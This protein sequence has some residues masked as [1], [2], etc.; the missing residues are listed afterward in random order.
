M[1]N[2][3]SYTPLIALTA[4]VASHLFFFKIGERHLYPLRYIQAFILTCAITTVAVSH[5]GNVPAADA[6]RSTALSSV[7][8]LTGLYTSVIIYRL[9]FN[10]LNKI[11]GPYW[12]RLSRFNLVSRVAAKMNC[13]KE[14]TEL[15]QKYGKFVRIGPN[16]LSVTEPEA[17]EVVS[18]NKSKC[19]KAEWY[20]QDVPLISMHTCRDRASHDRRR[21]IW[22]PAFSDK[23]LRGYETRIQGYNDLLMQKLDD[24]AGQYPCTSHSSH[25]Y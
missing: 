23:A 21:R 25:G 2:P 13:Y 11:P 20:S 4:G 6:A 3:T 5:Y 1:A 16:E 22:S 15:H 24:H 7:L 18:G 14:L 19:I 12:A 10:P 8:F 9:F 17:V